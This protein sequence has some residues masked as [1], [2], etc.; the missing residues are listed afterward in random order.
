M[1][2]ITFLF[3][4][5][6]MLL[7]S[8]ASQGQMT[9][10]PPEFNGVPYYGDPSTK[11]LKGFERPQVGNS[12]QRTGASVDAYFMC[13]GNKSPVSFSMDK[14]PSIYVKFP[15]GT[16]PAAMM[17]L[18]IM[19]SNAGLNAR[20]LFIGSGGLTSGKARTTPTVPI[21]Y[22]KVG[23]G[24]YRI[25][26]L[27]PLRP[28]EYAFFGQGKDMFCFSVYDPEPVVAAKE[29]PR[30]KSENK[31]FQKGAIYFSLG[32]YATANPQIGKYYDPRLGNVTM[33]YINPVS[34]GVLASPEFGVGRY[35]GFGI[36]AGL[37]GYKSIDFIYLS[38]DGGLTRYVA[39]YD[40]V[41]GELPSG[42]HLSIPIGIETN[43]H[44]YQLI[45][46][47]SAKNIHGDKL[48]LYAGL[49]AGSGPNIYF[50]S[51]YASGYRTQDVVSAGIL[52]IGPHFG[53]RY[54]P[55]PKTGFFMELGYG[56][57]ILNIGVVMRTK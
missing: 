36:Y 7:I 30:S 1:K 26:L 15:A 53:M 17:Q 35:V 37:G 32:F 54:F 21:D 50:H 43:F 12:S 51:I 34:V 24:L 42:G 33:S 14:V 2:Q 28:G 11:T 9:Y 27:N 5:A 38:D 16:D 39:R 48:D 41:I 20:R 31:A 47:K 56:K 29:T 22:V 44:F 49:A 23:E 25:E 8:F 6:A 19:E 13:S 4:G 10:P 45:Q 3:L 46:D 18:G 55:N 57:S 52:A 40:N